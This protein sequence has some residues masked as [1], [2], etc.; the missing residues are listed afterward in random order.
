MPMLIKV[1]SGAIPA[2]SE[3]E[4]P[5]API[6]KGQAIMLL[7]RIAVPIALAAVLVAATACAGSS[8]GSSQAGSASSST[9][10]SASA[11]P[12]AS[13][14]SS[15]GSSSAASMPASASVDSPSSSASDDSTSDSPSF[16]NGGAALADTGNLVYVLEAVNP[17]IG[18]NKDDLVAK[19]KAL[20]VH[21]NANEPE[22]QLE[23]DAA[24]GFTNG[25][26][27]PSDLEAQAIVGTVKAYAGC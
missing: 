27:V 16:V 4:M 13:A 8:G 7:S 3:R 26:W 1:V 24:K 25:A 17:R 9:A 21:V 11:A 18:T 23:S 5:L 10:P 15:V 22:G 2:A 6:V 12:T 19:S 14:S 20:C